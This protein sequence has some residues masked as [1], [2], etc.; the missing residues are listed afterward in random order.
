MSWN[1]KE[2][3]ETTCTVQQVKIVDAEQAR[4]YDSYKNAKCKLLIYN[5]C[6]SWNIKEI[7]CGAGFYISSPHSQFL[8][9]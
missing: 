7:K 4:L 9:Q 2:I 8:C 6:M 1:V 5:R 3:I